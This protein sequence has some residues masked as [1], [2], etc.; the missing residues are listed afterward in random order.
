MLDSAREI[1]EVTGEH[2]MM[3]F[4]DQGYTGEQT[5]EDAQ[6]AG[7]ELIVVKVDEAKKG[8]VLLPRRWLVDRSFGWAA[9]F[10]RL[11]RD[12]ERTTETLTGL[13]FIAFAMLMLANFVKSIAFVV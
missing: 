4:V 10:R 5:K 9:H 12:F 8:F 13:H 7:I 1:Q 11:V 6:A 3:A 2:V